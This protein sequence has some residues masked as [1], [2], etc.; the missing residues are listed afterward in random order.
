MQPGEFLLSI[1]VAAL[2]QNAVRARITA[3]LPSLSSSRLLLR[4]GDINEGNGAMGK[5][6]PLAVRRQ[7]RHPAVMWWRRGVQRGPH[8]S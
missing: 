4:C 1:S 5:S 2:Y 3:D 7:W 8:C 6:S